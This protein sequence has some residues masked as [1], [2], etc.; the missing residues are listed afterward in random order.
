MPT[1]TLT[2]SEEAYERLKTWKTNDEESY[3]HLILRLL[4]KKRDISKIIEEFE[5]SGLGISE[6]A[7]AQLKKDIE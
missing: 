6:E 7:A 3:S 4:P 1:K 5:E 2:L